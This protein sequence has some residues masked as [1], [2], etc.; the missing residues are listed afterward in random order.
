MW[1]LLL[2]ARARCLSIIR[3]QM[4]ANDSERQRNLRLGKRLSS[5]DLGRNSTDLERRTENF[6]P[7]SWRAEL[8]CEHCAR[9][10]YGSDYCARKGKH[11]K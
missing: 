4:P 8:L 5:A 11:A 1:L 3:A 9:S 6:V 7:L 10:S 2:R